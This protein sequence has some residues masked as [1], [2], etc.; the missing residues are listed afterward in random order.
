MDQ[1]ATALQRLADGET[2]GR[3]VLKF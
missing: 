3:L 2:V 1:A